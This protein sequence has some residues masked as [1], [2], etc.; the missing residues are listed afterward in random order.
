MEITLLSTLALAL[1]AATAT[2][3][4]D[5]EGLGQY[6]KITVAIENTG[7]NDVTALVWGEG[8]GEIYADNGTLGAAALGNLDAGESSVTT[9]T[10]DDIP[11]K[12]KLTATSTSGTTLKIHI[13]G[14]AKAAKLFPI[15]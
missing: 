4:A 2:P 3:I 11:S 1:A 9:L 15:C 8:A 13:V 14:V 7:S 10:G 5:L 12:L 6:E